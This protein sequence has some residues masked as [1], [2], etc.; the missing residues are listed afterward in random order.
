MDFSKKGYEMSKMFIYMISESDMIDSR[1]MENN[2]NLNMIL[3]LKS[4]FKFPMLILLTH[5][6]TFCDKIKETEKDWKDICKSQLKNNKINLLKWINDKFTTDKNSSND[7]IIDENDIKHVFLVEN[8]LEITD[9]Y[10]INSFDEE[11]RKDYDDE[12]DNGKKTMIKILKKELIWK[13][14]LIQG[15]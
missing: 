9:E 12:N 14:L 10:I 15:K 4:K 7:S 1:D 11:Q 13:N 2:A 3:E 5:S 6:D 8:D